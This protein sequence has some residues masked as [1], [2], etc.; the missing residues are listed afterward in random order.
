MTLGVVSLTAA[1]WRAIVPGI[2]P[3][4]TEIRLPLRHEDIIRQQAQDKRLDPALVAAVIYAESRFRDDQE[5]PAGA[6]GLMQVT[7][8]TAR[9]IARASGGSAFVLGDLHTPQV[10]IAYGTYRLRQ[11][12]DRFGDETP[13]ALAAYNAGPE[14]AKVW[15]ARDR[16]RGRGFTVADIP[17][18]ETRNYVDKVLDA[19]EDYRRTYPTELGLE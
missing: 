19:R 7:P 17:F 15:L 12:M 14:N 2:E 16:A 3:A 18:P 13:V 10:N 6:M 11:M 1:A 9:D 5:S 8:D 4:V